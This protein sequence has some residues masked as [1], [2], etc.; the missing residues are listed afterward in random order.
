[1][2]LLSALLAIAA[3]AGCGPVQSTA[4]LIDAEVAVE[5]A[6]AAGARENATYEYAVA[7]AYLKKARETANRA[8]YESANQ[9]ARKA[10]D[11]ANEARTKAIAATPRGETP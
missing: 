10:K 4:S 7:E 8:R 1:V 6:R 9:F 11:L 3:L 2:R 5:A